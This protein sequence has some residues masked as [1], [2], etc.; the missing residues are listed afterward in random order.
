MTNI[1]VHKTCRHS[2]KY[3]VSC[4]ACS[5]RD[6]KCVHGE[7]KTV[8][9]GV[10]PLSFITGE[11]KDTKTMVKQRHEVSH[12]PNP[13]LQREDLGEGTYAGKK[14]KDMTREELY[15]A[16]KNHDRLYRIALEQNH[17]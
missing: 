15:A 8:F 10:A 12:V 4:D 3:D 6:E 11:E 13:T 17:V 16:L 7:D 1:R 9:E 14:L 2:D 5:L